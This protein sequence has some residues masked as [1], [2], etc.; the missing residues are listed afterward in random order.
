MAQRRFGPIQAAGVAVIEQEAAKSISPG[1]LGMTCYVGVLERGDVGK[2]I[3]VLNKRDLEK[4]CGSLLT[5]FDLPLISRHFFDHDDG[6]GTLFLYRITDGSEVKAERIFSG[7]AKAWP[8]AEILKIT[9]KNGGA[10]GGKQKWLYDLIGTPGTDLTETAL[11]TKLTMKKNEWKGGT[12]KLNAVDK[13]YT[14]VSNTAAGVITVASDSTM[15]TDFG[16]ATDKGYMLDL[17]NGGK[18][19]SVLFKDGLLD[20]ANNFGMEVYLDG[21]LVLDYSE[22]SLDSAS[23]YFI[24]PTVNDDGANEYVKVAVLWTGSVNPLARPANVFG[25]VAVSP[26][27]NSVKMNIWDIVVESPT[28]ANPT[29]AAVT[30]AATVKPDVLTLEVT[31]DVT[32]A[33]SITS[34]NLGDLGTGTIGVAKTAGNIYTLGFTLNDGATTL[35]TGDI[36]TVYILPLE[37]GA[38]KGY[39]LIPDS[40][41]RRTTFRVK[42]NTHDTITVPAGVNLGDY[43]AA[44]KWLKANY[45]QALSGGYNGTENLAET[46]YIQ[47]FESGSPLEGLRDQKAFIKV[48][49]PSVTAPAVQKA[50]AA[51]A[52]RLNFQFRYEIPSSTVD[53]MEAEAYLN[54]TLGRNDFGVV[55]FPSFVKVANPFGAGKKLVSATG[56]IHGREAKIAKDYNGYHKAAAGIEVTL[57]YVLELPTG[58][59]ILDEEILNPQG[60]QVIKF[61]A[62]N[63]IIWGDRTT[64]LDPAWK[65]KHQR[66]LMSYYEHDMMSNF[67]WIIF[68]LNTNRTASL[69]YAALRNYFTAEWTKEA[70]QGEKFSDACGIKID[71]EN[72]TPATKAAG[73]L[74]AEISLWLADTVERF[75]IKMSKSSGL[76][77]GVA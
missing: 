19:V 1:K 41:N 64:A 36:V 33:F 15:K 6:G 10:W 45:P 55:A 27:D 4:K 47:A 38:L 76:E 43:T 69:A 59:K 2:V 46:N 20:P 29:L 26:T 28:G 49:V 3:P 34:D 13:V 77:E 70:L 48:A 31:D 39:I 63:A 61:Y 25:E 7:R 60:I 30:Y 68:M 56:M 51:F 17:Q 67:N 65:W 23:K 22:L 73:E 62:G 40:D 66:E 8:E 44:G 58:D 14:I 24:T 35:K 18:A 9:A 52:E 21:E 57:P 72:N 50:G 5:D 54:D 71:S 75:I 74:N 11:D 16:S 12:L 42:D 32:G 37:S 53:E